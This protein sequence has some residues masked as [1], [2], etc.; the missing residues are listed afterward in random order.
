[1]TELFQHTAFITAHSRLLYLFSSLVSSLLVSVV[2]KDYD[3][4]FFQSEAT[5]SNKIIERGRKIS[6][7]ETPITY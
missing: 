6:N 1:M 7:A 2:Q 3:S 4:H 5:P